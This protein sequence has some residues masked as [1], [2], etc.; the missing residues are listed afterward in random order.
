MCFC[1]FISIYVWLIAKLSVSRLIPLHQN[2]LHKFTTVG[3][4][5]TDTRES[6]D[7]FSS[8][9]FFTSDSSFSNENS[10]YPWFFSATNCELRSKCFHY[11]GLSMKHGTFDIHLPKRTSTPRRFSILSGQKVLLTEKLTHLIE[12]LYRIFSPSLFT[13]CGNRRNVQTVEFCVRKVCVHLVFWLTLCQCGRES[14]AEKRIEETMCWFRLT[15]F[16]SD[17][18]L[19]K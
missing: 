1:T 19:H 12:K 4:T 15:H 10:T 16:T 18:K 14:A 9:Y 13:R 2:V 11:R 17:I 8:C 3:N 7:M 5:R 6:K